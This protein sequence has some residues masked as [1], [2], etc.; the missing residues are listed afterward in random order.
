VA[1]GDTVV[2]GQALFQLHVTG[3]LLY[4]YIWTSYEVNTMFYRLKQAAINRGQSTD[5]QSVQNLQ[6]IIG[7]HNR[8]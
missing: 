6:S 3:I 8:L 4:D 7:Y 2:K 1:D 5:A